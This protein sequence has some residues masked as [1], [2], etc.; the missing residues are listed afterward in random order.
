LTYFTWA[1]TN[2][3]KLCGKK[4]N[5]K[6]GEAPPLLELTGEECFKDKNG[7]NFGS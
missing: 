2:I 3:P 4:E 6:Y 1:A 7:Y 5:Y